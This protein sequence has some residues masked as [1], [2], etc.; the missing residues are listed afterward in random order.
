MVSFYNFCKQNIINF[1]LSQKGKMELLGWIFGD[2]HG[3]PCCAG[4]GSRGIKLR[5]HAAF[6]H[7]EGRAQDTSGPPGPTGF[8]P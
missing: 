7:L 8:D 2:I 6:F 3:V 5:P 4:A 1:I